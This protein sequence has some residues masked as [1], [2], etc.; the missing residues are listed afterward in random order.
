[1]T[2]DLPAKDSL[3]P[4]TQK[5]IHLLETQLAITYPTMTIEHS[6]ELHR[7]PFL[8]L[9]VGL[10]IVLSERH[11]SD[12]KT[13]IQLL[14]RWLRF[15]REELPTL[16]YCQDMVKDMSFLERLY[17][18]GIANNFPPALALANFEEDDQIINV[19]SPI[20]SVTLKGS[21]NQLFFIRTPPILRGRISARFS[22]SQE[23]KYSTEHIIKLLLDS[24]DML[25]ENYEEIDCQGPCILNPPARPLQVGILIVNAR[26]ALN[27][28]FIK[29]FKIKTLQYN[30]DI[31]IIIETRTS[32][33]HTLPTRR[34]IIY[35]SSLFIKSAVFFGGFWLLWNSR[36]RSLTLHSSLY[37]DLCIVHHFESPPRLCIVSMPQH[38]AEL[39]LRHH[40]SDKV[41][42]FI[43]LIEVQFGVSYEEQ[44]LNDASTFTYLLRQWLR[45]THQSRRI[46][47]SQSRLTTNHD[48]LRQIYSRGIADL[49]PPQLSM[50]QEFGEPT[51][52][53]L[54][55][56]ESRITMAGER[57]EI[58]LI[59]TPPMS[60]ARFSTY[61]QVNSDNHST[62]HQITPRV[63]SP[64]QRM[65]E[66][67]MRIMVINAEGAAHPY[68]MDAFSHHCT[69][70]HPHLVVITETRMQENSGRDAR[71]S[72][73][74]PISTYISP[75]GYFGGQWWLWNSIDF[76]TQL[77]V[78]TNYS[79]DVDIHIN[80]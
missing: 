26:G 71:S 29:K 50:D 30:P 8:K 52:L 36:K 44:A 56:T 66:G 42:S 16:F 1:M 67:Q 28:H 75:I 54:T 31:V 65:Q 61:F 27:P 46:C 17:Q 14:D 64:N 20:T 24:T 60:K 21:D 11:D 9:I 68:L 47:S 3:L 43:R 23:K 63:Q 69:N 80:I 15:G 79:L 34:S 4:T 51:R 18:R 77:D 19:T 32:V 70:F 12:G 33:P 22:I 73:G 59:T 57:R 62:T 74:F 53:F 37:S 72:M 5:F 58:L 2:P 45:L 48:V 13:H 10:I 55:D 39:P 35:D 49:S 76:L 7:Q 78:R 40:L 25:F 6:S 41:Q 38:I